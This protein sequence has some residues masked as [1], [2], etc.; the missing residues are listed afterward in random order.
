MTRGTSRTT[1]PSQRQ[2]TPAA[3]HPE[4]LDTPVLKAC[5]LFFLSAKGVLNPRNFCS[6]A[7]LEVRRFYANRSSMI[8][9]RFL[10]LQDKL[11]L[12]KCEKGTK[13]RKY[14]VLVACWNLN[15]AMI[16][17][18]PALLAGLASQEISLVRFSEVGSAFLLSKHYC[19]HLKSSPHGKSQIGESHK[20][21]AIRPGANPR[22]TNIPPPCHCHARS[23]VPQ[24]RLSRNTST[25]VKVE[26]R[27]LRFSPWR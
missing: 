8:F 23:P 7:L 21:F 11:V 12:P 9:G 20:S 3:G 27:Q 13:K 18:H 14:I 24:I 16:L 25:A 1:L 19:W 15:G 4:Q 26:I 6:A 10:S 5:C 17:P 22:G 2:S